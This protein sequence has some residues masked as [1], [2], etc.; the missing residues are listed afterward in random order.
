MA[1]QVEKV[2]KGSMEQYKMKLVAGKEG[3]KYIIS[4]VHILENVVVK[5]YVRGN[6]FVFTTGIVYQ[7]SEWLLEFVKGLYEYHVSALAIN[8][9]PYIQE[10]PE[11]VIRFCDDH[12]FPLF[13]LPWEVQ[14][15]DV[16]KN[17]CSQI[18]EVDIYRPDIFTYEKR[19]CV[20]IIVQILEL[21]ESVAF[22][23]DLFHELIE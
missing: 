21:N 20:R 7:N 13:T 12:A 18:I 6:E 5:G 1:I 10:I 4:W 8:I 9:G 23:N 3:L 2:Y 11:E 15:I 14:I 19:I 17:Y 16:T 22:C